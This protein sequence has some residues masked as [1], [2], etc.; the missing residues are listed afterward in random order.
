[1]A[2]ILLVED[3]KASLDYASALLQKKSHLVLPARTIAEAWNWLEQYVT[4]DLIFLDSDLGNEKGW[5]FLAALRQNMILKYLPVVVYTGHCE[6]REVLRYMQF[7][8]QHY[9]VKPYDIVK[10][11]REIERAIG[12]NWVAGLFTDFRTVCEAFNLTEQQYLDGLR[13]TA[14]DID[15]AHKQL[16]T[17]ILLGHMEEVSSCLADL[18][19]RTEIA[20]F[21]GLEEVL[22]GLEAAAYRQDQ[23][24]AQRYICFF[25]TL[26]KILDSRT[27]GLYGVNIRNNTRKTIENDLDAA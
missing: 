20:G 6:K 24:D 7:S 11:E 15:E 16:E 21:I 25:P 23:E 22:L 8:V 1:M 10:L 9:L 26:L 13:K 2:N 17:E 19:A 3:D 18:R 4:L 14:E 27:E 5:D 12:S